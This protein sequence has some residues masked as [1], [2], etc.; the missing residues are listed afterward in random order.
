LTKVCSYQ[1]RFGT[2]ETLRA[3]VL[4]RR[5][6]NGCLECSREMEPAQAR[7]RCQVTASRQLRTTRD[8]D[9]SLLQRRNDGSDSRRLSIQSRLQLL[10][11]GLDFRW[12]LAIALIDEQSN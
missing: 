10:E 11:R 3:D 9:L 8:G 2:L 1:Q 12:R 7:N 5:L 6:A 4:V